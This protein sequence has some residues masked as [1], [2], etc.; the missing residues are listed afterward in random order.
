MRRTAL[1]PPGDI[2]FGSQ[3]SRRTSHWREF[4]MG[5]WALRVAVLGFLALLS[6]IFNPGILNET[7]RRRLLATVPKW[8]SGC[9]S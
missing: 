5:L 4:Q 9:L 2:D 7:P 3:P 1:F 8:C 6:H